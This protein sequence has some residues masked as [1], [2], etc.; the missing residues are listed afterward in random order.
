[1]RHC[2]QRLASGE[3]PC[4]GGTE[5]G[6]LGIGDAQIKGRRRLAHAHEH[7]Q[8]LPGTKHAAVGIGHGL[9]GHRQRFQ[10]F[11]GVQQQLAQFG[12]ERL[13]G[14]LGRQPLVDAAEG[15]KHLR[16]GGG[17]LAVAQHRD[18]GVV[19]LAQIEGLG[20]A[21]QDPVTPVVALMPH[22]DQMGEGGAART[23]LVSIAHLLIRIRIATILSID[24]EPVRYDR[25][26][27]TFSGRRGCRLCCRSAQPSGGV[28]RRG[29]CPAALRPAA[30]P[31]PR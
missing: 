13:P 5:A 4:Q 6:G 10:G 27:Y 21:R 11:G 2:R 9:G 1:M 29:G 26:S 17:E 19:H 8:Q 16:P 25:H 23:E 20:Q 24:Q 22:L 31:P 3:Q 14:W 12:G 18:L 15:E 30:S 28:R 7:L